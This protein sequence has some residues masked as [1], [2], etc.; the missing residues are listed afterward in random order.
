MTIDGG[1]RDGANLFA[2]DPVVVFE[3]LSPETQKA[4]RTVKLDDYNQTPSIRHY[5]LIEPAEPLVHVYS[6]GPH[7]DFNLRPDEVRGL[8]AVVELPAV[9]I[10]IG[11]AEIYDGVDARAA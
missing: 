6:R 3:V 10:S 5:V 7:G 8:D 11:M 4:G 9:G 1:P 2:P